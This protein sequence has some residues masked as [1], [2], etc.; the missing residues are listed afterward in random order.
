MFWENYTTAIYANMT[1]RNA[2]SA[3]PF[4][5]L[6]LTAQLYPEAVLSHGEQLLRVVEAKCEIESCADRLQFFST[7]MKHARLAGNAVT[8]VST[9]ALGGCVGGQTTCNV[10]ATLPVLE[11]LRVVRQNAS[12]TGAINVFEVTAADSRLGHDIA[13]QA[14][15]G[16]AH[17][18]ASSGG[19]ANGRTPI[20]LLPT[21]RWK[22]AIDPA[23]VGL[24][25][26]WYNSTVWSAPRV[27]S[28]LTSVGAAWNTSSSVVAWS[29]AHN[30]Q[31]YSGVGWYRGAVEV[32]EAE[33]KLQVV[34]A[35]WCGA[36]V[37]AWYDG[38]PL[39]RAQDVTSA[40][41][42]AFVLP[43]PTALTIDRQRGAGEKPPAP[44]MLTLRV[45]GGGTPCV[46]GYGLTGYLWLVRST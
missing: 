23:D 35:G 28:V 15:A 19:T 36:K 8:A 5:D 32:P 13:G 1:T 25:A 40:S 27:E 29:A 46:A 16:A 41:V 38:R 43:D 6:Q 44:L 37:S 21:T 10:E 17:I 7:G 33:S 14:L 20:A 31:T 4:G 30:N 39:S 12:N 26:Y 45:D 34:V 18:L 24:S 42:A 11:A 2:A 22:F 3:V 9:A